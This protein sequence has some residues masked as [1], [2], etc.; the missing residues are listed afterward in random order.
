MERNTEKGQEMLLRSFSERGE[1]LLSE[2]TNRQ[3]DGG[4]EW[5]APWERGRLR[6]SEAIRLAKEQVDMAE[7]LE[8]EA[9]EAPIVHDMCRAIAEVYMLASRAPSAQIVISGESLPA[10]MVAEIL[11]QVTYGIAVD[12]ATEV[13]M[14]RVTCP[15]AYLRSY[16][17]HRVMEYETAC[18]K[19]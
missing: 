5:I 11:S 4:G 10:E 18:M 2:P 15:K 3:T 17:Y 6:F 13:D 14:S 12:V 19:T 7:L 16:L 1:A 9:K 8:T